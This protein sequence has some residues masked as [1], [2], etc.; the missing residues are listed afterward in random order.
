M[1]KKTQ[2]L[3]GVIV[4]VLIDAIIPFFPV[5]GLILIYVVLEKPPWFIEIVREIY[6]KK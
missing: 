2:L 4:L 1:N 5:L 3:L 6:N